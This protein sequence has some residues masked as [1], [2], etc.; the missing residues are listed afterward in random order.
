MN[1]PIEKHEGDKEKDFDFLQDHSETFLTMAY[2]WERRKVMER[3]CGVGVRKGDCGDT[4]T[5]YLNIS[6]DRI[7]E[8][9]FELKGCINTSACCNAL[10]ILVEGRSV[11]K[12][13]EIT[14]NDIIDFL[15]TLPVDHHHCAEL[16]V[17]AFYLALKDCHD[18]E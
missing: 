15:V 3:P 8:V 6:N 10:A 9:S 18:R 4:I 12:A 17:G 2:N 14:P 13:W 1:Q 7:D 5:L 11:E 16:A